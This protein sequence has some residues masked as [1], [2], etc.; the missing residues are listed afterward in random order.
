MWISLFIYKVSTEMLN[1]Q[2]DFDDKNQ[3]VQTFSTP[4]QYFYIIFSKI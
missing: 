3:L 4:P 2:F 1:M